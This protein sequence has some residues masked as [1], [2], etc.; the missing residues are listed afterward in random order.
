MT[1]N[2]SITLRVAEAIEACG[3][4]YLLS[5]SFASNY[6]GIPRSTRDADFVLQTAR[7]VGQEFATQLG[8][9]FLRWKGSGV[10]SLERHLLNYQVKELGDP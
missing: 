5:G 6:Y 3:I 7:A 4:P 10:R 8:E 2:E 1:S 9:D